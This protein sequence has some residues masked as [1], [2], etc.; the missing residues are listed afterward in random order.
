MKTSF[1]KGEWRGDPNGCVYAFDKSFP[2]ALRVAD[3]NPAESAPTD[4]IPF[5]EMIANL[6]LIAAGPSMFHALL[7]C[8]AC[9][10][11][12]SDSQEDYAVEIAQA[13]EALEQA[14]GRQ[15]TLEEIKQH[16]PGH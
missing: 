2:H 4:E 10:T 12:D 5:K 1:T 7:A 16:D 15:P 11:M 14:L 3:C 13:M 6:Q 9:L 8:V